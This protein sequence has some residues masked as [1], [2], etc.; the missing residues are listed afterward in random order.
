MMKV[1]FI[2]KKSKRCTKVIRTYTN[3]D[4]KCTW[5][6]KINVNKSEMK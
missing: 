1:P 2:E 3:N 6:D 5:K 4:K